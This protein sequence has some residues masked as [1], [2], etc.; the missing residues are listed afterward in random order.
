MAVPIIPV[1]AAFVKTPVG[2]A[3]MQSLALHASVLAIGIYSFVSG[4]STSTPPADESKNLLDVKINPKDPLPTPAGWSAPTGGNV[5]PT[6]PATIP[7]TTQTVWSVPATAVTAAQSNCGSMK[8][9]LDAALAT[10]NK[11][12]ITVASSNW[13]C[14]AMPP[15]GW[16]GPQTI[17]A[18]SPIICTNPINGS[19]A[20]GWHRAGVGFESVY[21][22][23]STALTCPAGYTKSGSN[24]NLSNASAVMKPA[25]SKP[26]AVMR[27]GNTFAKDPQD[28]D[29]MPANVVVAPDKI[30]VTSDDGLKKVE[31]TI[32]ADGS[33]KV[34][35]TD[36]TAGDGKTRQNT[37]NTSA[38]SA[39][40]TVEATGYSSKTFSG[41]GTETSSTPDTGEKMPTDYN[42]ENT[43]QQIKQ[44][45]DAIREELKTDT[46]PDMPNQ[47]DIVSQAKNQSEAD[48]S[49]LH[50]SVKTSVGNDQSMWTSW[51]WTPQAATCNDP[52]MTVNG[53]T[54]SLPIC[55]KLG[56]LRDALGF[57]FAI[58][59][60]WDIYQEIFRR[61]SLL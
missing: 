46:A 8:S 6:P 54:A 4:S 25:D 15:S 17:S 61:R 60:A 36:A 33:T 48:M 24:C 58:Y 50:N 20:Y 9:C 18:G 45:L 13:P 43:Q 30:T 10:L 12:L 57:V 14:E 41:T 51:I 22:T 21:A 42:R 34:I 56:M 37:I 2:K 53:V 27:N 3:T 44:T 26:P 29:P 16:F 19:N 38:P 47:S 11:S 7:A 5:Q 59:A 1:L 35:E 28:P 39:D 32:A 49:T 31:A 23:S 55:S 52:S 40:G